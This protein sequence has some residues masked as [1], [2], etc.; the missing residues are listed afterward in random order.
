MVIWPGALVF[1]ET[2]HNWGQLELLCIISHNRL[3]PVPTCTCT[4]QLATLPLPMC[5]L[6]W[7]CLCKLP[8][9]WTP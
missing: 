3:G 4:N 9:G 8:L 5:K 1:L 7:F 2:N 6:L